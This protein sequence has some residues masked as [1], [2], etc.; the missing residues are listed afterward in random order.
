MESQLITA[1][2][3]ESQARTYLYMLEHGSVSPPLIAKELNLTRT[4]AYKVLDR[5]VELRLVRQIKIKNKTVFEPD[6]PLSLT[7]LAAEQ[8]NIATAREEAVKSVIGVM[9]E[10][11]HQHSESPMIQAVTGRAAVIQAYQQQ[12]SLLE[13]L[14]FIRSRS[15]IPILGFDTMHDIRIKPSHHDVKRYGIT[16]DLNTGPIN[17]DSDKRSN[18]ERTWVKQ[19]DY[20]AP[21]EWS[22]SGS[23]LLIILFGSE[24]HAVTITS[25]LIAD[26]F[27]QIWSLLDSGLRNAPYYNELPRIPNK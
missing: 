14:Y 18:L 6:N 3:N 27:R 9:L 10:K 8:R 12:I 19:E 5:L 1:G 2:L 21:V 15:D 7:N 20:T 24:P 4:N 23:V 25:P 17:P 13:P 11:Y 22:V 16:P 26:A